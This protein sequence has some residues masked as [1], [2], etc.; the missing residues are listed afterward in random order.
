MLSRCG[1]AL[2]SAVRG[3][4][5]Q[6]QMNLFRGWVAA[7]FRYPDLK[8]VAGEAKKESVAKAGKTKPPVR[9]PAAGP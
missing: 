7:R 3:G 4:H 6:Q 2:P 8:S 1:C 5:K 9:R